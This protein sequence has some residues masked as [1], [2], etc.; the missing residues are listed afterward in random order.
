MAHQQEGSDMVKDEDEIKVVDIII[1]ESKEE[2]G[3]EEH[4]NIKEEEFNDYTKISNFD[5]EEEPR[6]VMIQ[7]KNKEFLVSRRKVVD[8]LRTASFHRGFKEINDTTF[9]VTDFSNKQ[10]STECDVEIK[11]N[12]Y[13]GKCKGKCKVTI[14]KDNKKKEGK[15]QQTLMITKKAKNK[16]LHVRKVTR[17]MQYLLDGFMKKEIK[18]A[19]VVI[20]VKK[21]CDKCEKK[22]S[23]R[24]GINHKQVKNA[25]GEERGEYSDI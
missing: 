18:E 9:K 25:W 17:L 14:Y 3:W 19:D 11:Y 13:K 2:N 21:D 20:A 16:S 23:H 7:G 1:E 5:E 4:E 6:L 22:V 15:K 10:Y 12:E 24:T 8:V